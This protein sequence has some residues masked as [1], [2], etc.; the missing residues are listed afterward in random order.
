M[1]P[2]SAPI[3]KDC[4]LEK[5]TRATAQRFD[6][7]SESA[8]SADGLAAAAASLQSLGQT[9]RSD[10]TAASAHGVTLTEQG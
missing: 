1:S 5:P 3:F 4:C 6:L 9:V 8:R 2:T 7:T 10:L